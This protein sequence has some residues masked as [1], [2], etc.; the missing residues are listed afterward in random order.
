MAENVRLHPHALVRMGER[1]ASVSEV[2]ETVRRGERFPVKFDRQGFR[3]NF[4][5]DAIWRGRHY[6]T[7]QIEAIA[8]EEDGGWLV[9][10]V[11]VKYF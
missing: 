3:R 4:S 6:L 5:L 10:S 9:I 1:G 2:L 11:I 7:K 8:V